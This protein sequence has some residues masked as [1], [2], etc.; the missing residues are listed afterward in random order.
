MRGLILVQGRGAAVLRHIGGGAVTPPPL[1]T[2]F[3][4]CDCQKAHVA[5]VSRW[6]NILPDLM[7]MEYLDA[8]KPLAAWPG[9]YVA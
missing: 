1:S 8:G 3:P 6:R 5:S 4:L 9:L 2:H 7:P